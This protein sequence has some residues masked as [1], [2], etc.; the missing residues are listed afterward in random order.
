MKKEELRS[1]ARDVLK[2]WLY[3]G[4]GLAVFWAYVIGYCL[5]VGLGT[6]EPALGNLGLAVVTLLGAIVASKIVRQVMIHFEMPPNYVYLKYPGMTT[7]LLIGVGLAVLIHVVGIFIPSKELQEY[8]VYGPLVV[9]IALVFILV[10]RWLLE[11]A[12]KRKGR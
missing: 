1:E 5:L 12:A 2:V 10:V 8:F 7:A 3:L 6:L 11:D 4:F 9:S